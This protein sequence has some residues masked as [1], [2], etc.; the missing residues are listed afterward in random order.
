MNQ[1]NLQIYLKFKS[2]SLTGSFSKGILHQ[3]FAVWKL[4]FREHMTLRSIF[5][6]LLLTNLS[7]VFAPLDFKDYWTLLGNFYVIFFKNRKFLKLDQLWTHWW[8]QCSR[9]KWDFTRILK[10]AIYL[11]T[12]YFKDS[13]KITVLIIKRTVFCLIYQ[14]IFCPSK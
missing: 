7:Q 2:K 12:F 11:A 1:E 4:M 5:I 14:S 8:T 6:F 10:Q 13:F 9:T 3:P